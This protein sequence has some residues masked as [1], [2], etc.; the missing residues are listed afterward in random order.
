LT[1]LLDAPLYTDLLAHPERLRD[2]IPP[3]GEPWVILDEV[4]R[5]PQVL[6]EVHRLIEERKTRFIL[7]GSSARSLRRK[8]TNLLA[9]RALTFRMHPLTSIEL[10]A[11][12]R[13]DTSLAHGRLPPALAAADP[14]AFLKAYVQTYLRE[15]VQQEGFVRNIGS[16]S[17]FLEAASFSQ[18]SV[19]NLAEVARDC[20]VERKTVSGYFEIL[21][22][23]LLASTLPVFRRRA[24]RRLVSHPKFYFFDVGVYRALRPAGPLDKPEEID[25]VSLESLVY[26][27]LIALNDYLG[28]G[29]ELSFW[30]TSGGAEVDFVLY[31]ER[32]IIA[33]E[34]KRARRTSKADLAGLSLF[35]SDYPE[36][37][38]I[39]L[40]GGSRHEYREGVELIPIEEG[41]SSLAE[42]I[43][44]PSK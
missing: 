18:G 2:F 44:R 38:C 21:E 4:Q 17:R 41:L 39:L 11:D 27:E 34:V 33:L 3:R 10:G 9:G 31:G 13:F 7:T 6:N 29:Y 5:V 30:R 40:S 28:L 16:F 43:R 14:K 24:K 20:A 1:I 12:A 23:L 32:G 35:Q 25:G 8:G 37:R 26:Q 22:D 15:E 36:A 42:I 19:L